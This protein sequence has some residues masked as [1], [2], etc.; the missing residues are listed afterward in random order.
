MTADQVEDATARLYLAIGRLSRLLRRTGSPGRPSSRPMSSR[1]SVP[2]TVT[3]SREPASVSIDPFH[4]LI[5]RQHAD[6][7]VEIAGNER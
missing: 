4:K 3:V 6:N 2:V 1:F 5:E 7:V